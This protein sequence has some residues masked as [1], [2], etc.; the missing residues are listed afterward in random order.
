MSFQR[1]MLKS[2]DS[3]NPQ[4]ILNPQLLRL[5]RLPKRSLR[6]KLKNKLR[7][8]LQVRRTKILK[9]RNQLPLVSPQAVGQPQ[10]QML[11][12]LEL[13][14]EVKKKATKM[15][16]LLKAKTKRLAVQ[17]QQFPKRKQLA[18]LNQVA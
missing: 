2:P 8:L 15:I 17:R 16:I 13:R 9:A 5:A 14:K 3:R 4:L 10:E 11:Q 6:K 7:G 1:L 18:L 12:Q